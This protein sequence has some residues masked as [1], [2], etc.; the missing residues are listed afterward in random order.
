MN[1]FRGGSSEVSEQAMTSFFV[2]SYHPNSAVKHGTEV[3]LAMA[4]QIADRISDICFVNYISDQVCIRS[5]G[6]IFFL[7][8][9]YGLN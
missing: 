3:I 9:S 2:P 7:D 5:Q 6:W 8:S 4:Y 1:G